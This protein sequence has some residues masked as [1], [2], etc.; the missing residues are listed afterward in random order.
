MP[1]D[2]CSGNV[3]LEREVLRNL[4]LRASYVGNKTS[5]LLYVYR[6]LNNPVTMSPGVLQTQRP[7]QP[8]ASISTSQFGGDSTLHQLQLEAIQ[9]YKSADVPDRAILEPFAGRHSG[10]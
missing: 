4:G 1:L 10:N 8:W 9:R 2:S 6:E 5:H 7:Y 3:S